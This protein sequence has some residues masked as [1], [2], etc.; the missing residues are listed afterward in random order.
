MAAYEERNGLL[1]PVQPGD[2]LNEWRK[3]KGMPSVTRQEDDAA[4]KRI[5]DNLIKAI[6]T[7][8]LAV[9]HL[10]GEPPQS[11][12]A[13]QAAAVAAIDAGAFTLMEC[14][15]IDSAV[16]LLKAVEAR[17]TEIDKAKPDLPDLG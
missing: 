11:T 3:R 10:Y 17:L 12:G 9:G 13:L 7:E 6:T 14:V 5:K 8:A 4:L 16:A 2:K 1:L 15:G